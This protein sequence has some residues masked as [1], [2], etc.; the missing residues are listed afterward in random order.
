MNPACPKKVIKFCK[1]KKVNIGELEKEI[2]Q[3][4][5][6]SDTDISSQLL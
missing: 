5:D 3:T 6:Y 4:V 2:K 1:L